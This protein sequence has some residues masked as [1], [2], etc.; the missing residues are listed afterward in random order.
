MGT[1]QTDPEIEEIINRTAPQF[2]FSYYTLD[3]IKQECW[4]VVLSFPNY[5]D[6]FGIE[7]HLVNRLHC[8]KRSKIKVNK[9]EERQRKIDDLRKR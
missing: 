7:Q 2:V 4:A 1:G 8:W 6:E 5:L 9:T 3:D